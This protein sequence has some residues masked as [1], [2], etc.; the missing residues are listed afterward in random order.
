[1]ESAACMVESLWAMTITV[2]PTLHFSSAACTTRSDS[3]SSA[4][5]QR[6]TV[7]G[8]IK[9]ESYWGKNRPAWMSYFKYNLSIVVN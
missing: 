9:R 3:A 1:M 5:Q 7:N 4:L 6:P 2:L 8:I